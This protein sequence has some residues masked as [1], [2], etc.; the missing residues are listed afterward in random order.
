MII[1]K[2]VKTIFLIVL[3]VLILSGGGYLLWRINQP[4]TVAPED[5][6]AGLLNCPDDYTEF[7]MPEDDEG[8]L[9]CV[10]GEWVVTMPLACYKSVYDVCVDGEPG[11]VTYVAPTP[12]TTYTLR[13][14]AGSNGSLTGSATQTVNKGSSGTAVTAVP[15]S[16]YE[17]SKW[18]DDITT[19]PRTDSNVQGNI[20]V[21][22]EF[23][24]ES[25]TITLTYMAGPNGSLTGNTSQT[26]ELGEDGTAV[27]AVADSGYRFVKWHDG[28]TDNPRIDKNVYGPLAVTAEF[29]VGFPTSYTLGYDIWLDEDGN[30]NGTLTGDIAQ[31]VDPAGYGTAVTAVPNTG[32]HF[33]QWHDGVTDNPRTDG[34][35][36]GDLYSYAQF[37]VGGEEP[38]VPPG[39]GDTVPQTGIFDTVLGTVSVGTAFILLGGLVS[40]YSKLN[41]MFDSISE[42]SRFKKD[43]RRERRINRRRSKLEKRFK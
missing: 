8:A 5:S 2:K 16:G 37:T 4:E 14:T 36:Y 34:P 38:Q 1:S 39:T 21:T 17:F 42:R 25:S 24:V 41:Y 12:P 15:D 27:T 18:S 30:K 29:E 10:D 23:L 7:S 19:N 11:W 33:T 43:L 35:V 26:I 22:A 3:G 31:T 13:Y 32:Y 6:E 9:Y 20:T 28:V 40:Q